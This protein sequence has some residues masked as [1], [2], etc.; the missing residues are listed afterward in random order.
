MSTEPY[1]DLIFY[2]YEHHEGLVSN[3][4]GDEYHQWLFEVWT[5]ACAAVSQSPS[6]PHQTAATLVALERR[7]SYMGQQYTGPIYGRG[8]LAVFSWKDILDRALEAEREYRAEQTS[9]LL[10]GASLSVEWVLLTI[11]R[12]SKDAAT[13]D[14]PQMG[15]R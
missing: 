7:F 8:A 2:L 13:A 10:L 15:P 14:Q 1:R 6:T 11:K 4:T 3:M 9:E 5:K 12:I